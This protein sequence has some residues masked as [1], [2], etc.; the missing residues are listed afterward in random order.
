MAVRLELTGGLELLDSIPESERTTIFTA[1]FA[2]CDGSAFLTYGVFKVGGGP[3]RFLLTMAPELAIRIRIDWAR[4]EFEL[5][6]FTRKALY[7][8]QELDAL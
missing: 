3:D 7:W 6:G 5:L 8:P 1:L 4:S 2:I